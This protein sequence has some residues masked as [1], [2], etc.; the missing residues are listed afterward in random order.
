LGGENI[1]ISNRYL[2]P[3]MYEADFTKRYENVEM[4]NFTNK[5]GTFHLNTK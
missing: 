1:K 3:T 4:P 2:K 5:I